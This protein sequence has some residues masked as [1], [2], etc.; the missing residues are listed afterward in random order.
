VH[1]DWDRDFGWHAFGTRR[2]QFNLTDAGVEEFGRRHTHLRQCVE[3]FWNTLAAR[4][5]RVFLENPSYAGFT[6]FMAFNELLG[7]N[8]FA[9]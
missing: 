5:E 6:S 4:L 9:G 1:W 3:V 7:P 2:D 8:S